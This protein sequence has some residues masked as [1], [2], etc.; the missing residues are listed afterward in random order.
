MESRILKIPQV[1]PWTPFLFVEEHANS[2]F[3][4]QLPGCQASRWNL[5]MEKATMVIPASIF[6]GISS[7]R[8]QHSQPGKDFSIQELIINRFD[9]MSILTTITKSVDARH[10]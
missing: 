4:W 2:L 1:S 5:V 9:F 7:N 8:N 10:I 3:D 6:T